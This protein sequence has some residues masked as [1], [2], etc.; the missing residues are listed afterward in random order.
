MIKHRNLRF[1]QNGDS[2]RALVFEETDPILDKVLI[3]RAEGAWSLL[4][5][6]AWSSRL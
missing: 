2:E 4:I 1:E 3:E 5:E 6:R